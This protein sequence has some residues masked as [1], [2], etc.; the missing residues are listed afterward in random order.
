MTVANIVVY[1]EMS[2]IS[3]I[4]SFIARALGLIQSF[5]FIANVKEK[6][7]YKEINPNVR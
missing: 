4:N 1:Y 7:V 6:E 3:A 2:T 5:Y